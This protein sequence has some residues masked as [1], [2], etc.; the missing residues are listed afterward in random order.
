ME[1]LKHLPARLCL[2]PWDTVL[3][4]LNMQR[5]HREMAWLFY[6]GRCPVVT[7]LDIIKGRLGV[8]SGVTILKSL[9]FTLIDF[10]AKRGAFADV[11]TYTGAHI[12]V[13]RCV[14]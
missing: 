3:S 1:N 13:S 7:M 9:L 5:C 14:H 4:L 2:A 6:T 11:A 10:Q 8:T 12:D